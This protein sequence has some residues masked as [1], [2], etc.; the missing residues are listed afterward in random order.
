M[1]HKHTYILDIYTETRVG[2][3]AKAYAYIYSTYIQRK[4][5]T[6]IRHTYRDTR[7][8]IFDIHTEKS[9]YI[10]S[11][12]IQRKTHTYTRHTYRDTHIHT[13]HTYRDAGWGWGKGIRIHI[14]DIHTETHA[15]IL[16]IH[17]ETRVGGGA[18]AWH[19]SNGC[20]RPMAVGLPRSDTLITV[21]M[22]RCV[23]VCVCVCVLV[24]LYVL[25]MYVC[26]YV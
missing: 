8:R 3:G 20:K 23:C 15:Y 12:Y 14:F 10:Y 11:T 1:H 5:H 13:R 19:V 26:M 16:D 9:A 4:T 25:C 18:N 2:G 6:Y 17:T 21:S 24:H 7:I 22:L